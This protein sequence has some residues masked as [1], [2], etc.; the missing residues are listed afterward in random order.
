MKKPELIEKISPVLVK[1]ELSS[2]EIIAMTTIGVIALIA[3]L[4]L[5]NNKK[6]VEVGNKVLTE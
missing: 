2:I 1:E 5:I 3:G 4:L 6:N